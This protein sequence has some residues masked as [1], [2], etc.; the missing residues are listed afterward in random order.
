MASSYAI[1]LYCSFELLFGKLG[2]RDLS[3]NYVFEKCPKW[4][5]ALHVAPK[6]FIVVLSAVARNVVTPGQKLD[7]VALSWWL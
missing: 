1:V 4:K 7:G 5:N 2:G 3:E 6:N